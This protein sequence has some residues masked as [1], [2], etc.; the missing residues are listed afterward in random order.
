VFRLFESLVAEGKTILMV[1]HDD[2]LAGRA[3]RIL[4]LADG[5]MVDEV[6][7]PSAVAAQQMMRWKPVWDDGSHVRIAAQEARGRGSLTP[8]RSVS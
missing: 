7:R 5:L 1:T 2:E 6:L 8:A 3:P 4:T